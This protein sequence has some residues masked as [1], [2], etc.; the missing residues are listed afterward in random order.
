MS[1]RTDA[2]H[3][4]SLQKG[5]ETVKINGN[6]SN[7]N[8]FLRF[9][10]VGREWFWPANFGIVFLICFLE[11]VLERLEVFQQSWRGH[12]RLPSQCL[13]CFWPCL[14]CAQCKHFSAKMEQKNVR[15]TRHKSSSL[16]GITSMHFRLLHYYKYRNRR[17]FCPDCLAHIHQLW[18]TGSSEFGIEEP[19]K[20]H[21]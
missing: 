18:C 11:P 9:V 20:S 19:L 7:G 16:N 2:V 5:N 17:V 15:K 13:Q 4:Q 21:S 1:F 10:F 6:L 14:R 12:L 8:V 3:S